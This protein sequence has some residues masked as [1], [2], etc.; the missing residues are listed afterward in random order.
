M[1]LVGER[2]RTD[3]SRCA[4]CHVPCRV[5]SETTMPCTVHCAQRFVLTVNVH[6]LVASRIVHSNVYIAVWLLNAESWVNWIS[7]GFRISMICCCCEVRWRTETLSEFFCLIIW[8]EVDSLEMAI[9]TLIILWIR[10]QGRV[11][12]SNSIYFEFLISRFLVRMLTMCSVHQQR[13]WND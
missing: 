9:E 13:I 3:G 6:Y 10:H 1:H 11:R 7:S 5:S 4:T 2:V 12:S 8:F